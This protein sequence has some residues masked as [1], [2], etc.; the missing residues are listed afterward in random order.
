M[1]AARMKVLISTQD[2]LL[3]DEFVPA[4]SHFGFDARSVDSPAELMSLLNVEHHD[5]CV[6]DASRE[7]EAVLAAVARLRADA[8][9]GA[10]GLVS[11]G[12]GIVLLTKPDQVETRIH[13]L[14]IGADTYLTLPIQPRELAAIMLSIVRRMIPH[15]R[16]PEAAPAGWQPPRLAAHAGVWLLTDDN[17]LLISPDGVRLDLSFTE[18][19]LI[20]AM[21]DRPGQTLSREFIGNLLDESMLQEDAGKLVPRAPQRVSM[22]VSRLRKK[23]ARAGAG[24]PLR[25]VRGSGYAFVAPLQRPAPVATGGDTDSSWRSRDELIA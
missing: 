19:V 4:M 8:G 22:L 3:D 1:R 17:T 15:A 5:F 16:M 23:G 12:V 9:L 18:R 21:A 7:P 10:A 24:L 25:V 20:A 6:L 14:L 2:P 11:A 13:G